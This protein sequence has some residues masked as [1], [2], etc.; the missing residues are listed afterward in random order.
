MVK[1]TKTFKK[2]NVTKKALSAILAASMVMTS[3]SFVMAAPVEVEAVD[4]VE[5]V[6]AGEEQVSAIESFKGT[7]IPGLEK[8]A[9][10]DG[11]EAQDIFNAI[12]S[13]VI[14]RVDENGNAVANA[15]IDSFVDSSRYVVT[16][17]GKNVDV[18]IDSTNKTTA[19][20]VKA[21]S[22]TLTIEGTDI[23]NGTNSGHGKVT[24]QFTIV[25]E[26]DIAEVKADIK[27]NGAAPSYTGSAVEPEIKLT[28]GGKEL[29]KDED[30]TIL[31]YG[32]NTNAATGSGHGNEDQPYVNVKFNDAYIKLGTVKFNFT[33]NKLD[34]STAAVKTTV[35]NDKTTYNGKVQDPEVKVEFI[36][37]GS[38]TYVELAKENYTVKSSG[39]NKNAATYILT[40]T[41]KN[42]ATG[43]PRASVSYVIGKKAFTDSNISFEVS[44]VAFTG[45]ANESI[46]SKYKAAVVVK[47]ISSGQVLTEGTDYDVYYA[48]SNGEY[49]KTVPAV[50]AAGQTIA[51]KIVPSSN[52]SGTG[53][54]ASYKVTYLEDNLQ[55]YIKKYKPVLDA[56]NGEYTYDKDGVRPNYVT[57]NGRTYNVNGTVS[58]TATE[59]DSYFDVV[60]PEQAD[61]KGVGTYN[62]TLVG[63]GAW[64]GQTAE[65]PFKVVAKKLDPNKTAVLD[66]NVKLYKAHN[67][68][69]TVDFAGVLVD[70]DYKLVEGTDYTYTIEKANSAYNVKVSYKGNYAGESE[71]TVNAPSA[72]DKL[73]LTAEAITAEVTG[74]YIYTGAPIKPS[75]E[76]IVLKE[77]GVELREGIDY[78]IVSYGITSINPSNINVGKA[79]V[80]V[81]GKGDYDN[82]KSRTIVFEI[83]AGE[84]VKGNYALDTTN[85]KP[86][87][88]AG[89]SFNPANDLK[90]KET[91]SG[92]VLSSNEYT[93]KYF[94][95]GKDMGT[96]PVAS[97]GTT[98]MQ[99]TI[100]ETKTVLTATYRVATTLSK[101]AD[102][103]DIADQAFTGEAIEPE[104]TVTKKNTNVA[105]TEGTDYVVSY[106][107]N[108]KQGKATVT[109]EGIGDYYG[110]ITKTFKIAGQA[111]QSIEVL[112]A[113]ARDIQNRTLNSKATV[114]KFEAGK[115]PKT[116]VTYA[117]SDED[118]V[119]V[120][121]TGKITYTGLGE[122]T[123]TI[124]AAETAEYKAAETTMTVKVGLTKPSFTPFSKN[125]AFT[126]TSSTVKGAE[127][128]EVQYATKKDFSNKKSK[129]FTA[130]SGKV[131]QVKVSAGDKKTYYVRVRAI[132]GT[133]KS[134]WS[135]VKTVATK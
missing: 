29:V 30:Y 78:T 44:D 28:V 3:S 61:C 88:E 85:L 121:E 69:I 39:T 126:L 124:K 97:V 15:N 48:A 127:K 120:D 98:T 60:F 34:L 129:T 133:T 63:K 111:E 6:N 82:T 114:V 55:N 112:A 9:L 35:I 92:R 22:Y 123:I 115:A 71:K 8:I 58:G 13:I 2:G 36:P 24:G 80:V 53:K 23:S 16:V 68:Q 12:K 100:N 45:T 116:A 26:A 25:S 89:T 17:T 27:V 110:T 65:I 119:K 47:D 67:N 31:G 79:G 101:V 77:N 7:T 42:N 81:Q 43:G 131:R 94:K 128:F 130:T 38:T 70:G 87:Y 10:N 20:P 84:T 37:Q 41:G 91:K 132:S 72:A 62:I 1:Q 59:F 113:Q 18:T 64:A 135:N 95:D 4:V 56:A 117:S 105:M 108:V 103:K 19:M 86:V 49:S 11:M 32:N 5:D 93:I 66:N 107:N 73:P 118:V 46:D 74:E 40:I 14:E 122:A 54:L 57:I 51:I 134:A 21:G 90:V 99:I 104:V 109:V 75:K 96:S 83:K 76:N 33:I 50:T 125:N 106:T 52:Y 102:V